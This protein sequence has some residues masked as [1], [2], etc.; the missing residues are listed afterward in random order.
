MASLIEGR[1][2]HPTADLLLVAA[3]GRKLPA[4]MCILRQRAPV[5]FS[6]YIQPTLDATPRGYVPIEAN[7]HRAIAPLLEIAIGD[8]DS[9][10]LEFFIR[11]VYT[12]EEVSELTGSRPCSQLTDRQ[13]GNDNGDRPQAGLEDREEDSMGRRQS[14][15]D[16]LNGNNATEDRGRAVGA[17]QTNMAQQ[18]ISRDIQPNRQKEAIAQMTS[19]KE[20][21][22]QRSSSPA[23]SASNRTVGVKAGANVTQSRQSENKSIFSMFIGIDG[24]Q[25]ESCDVMSQSFPLHTAS[26]S[27][28]LMSCSFAGSTS[29][30]RNRVLAARKMSMSSVSSLTSVDAP[31]DEMI[32]IQLPPIADRSPAS[33]LAHDMLQMYLSGEDCDCIVE[34]DDG[35]LNAHRCVL[36]ATCDHFRIHLQ[37]DQPRGRIKLKG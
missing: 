33:G 8:V 14:S 22:N 13:G 2:A 17:Q 32:D 23:H 15:S 9:S 7:R 27:P 29:S 16:S 35:E 20:L 6:R 31:T 28:L 24:E 11:S 1:A 4:H 25:E 21:A 34:V 5:F 37:D 3:D 12:D 26:Q 30:I 36:W 10:G 18:P 19:F